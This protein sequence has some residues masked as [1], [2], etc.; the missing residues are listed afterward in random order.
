[1]ATPRL[2]NW[3]ALILR[4]IGAPVTSENIRFLNAWTQAEGGSASNN[5]FNTTDPYGPTTKYNSV[6]VRN[7][8]SPQQGIAATIH[9]LQNGHYGVLLDALRQ[10][11]SAMN[12]AIAESKTPWGT[13][14]LIIKVL[15]G[16]VTGGQPTPQPSGAAGLATALQ[17]GTIPTQPSNGP[18]PMALLQQ[19]FQSNA[20]LM[21]RPQS[22]YKAF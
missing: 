20:A 6:G 17:N 22:G 14:S 12:D 5:P 2:G 19:I 21:Q 4:G 3:Q 8:Q 13:G 10:G 7:Y 11:N 9:T 16:K 1:M 18:D 15:G